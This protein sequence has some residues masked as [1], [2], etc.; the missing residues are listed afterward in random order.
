MK[1]DGS[2][3]NEGAD[4]KMK[5]DDQMNIKIPRE[6]KEDFY[7]T[8]KQSRINSSALIRRWIEQFVTKE[9]AES[10][11]DTISQETRLDL[12]KYM[13]TRLEPGDDHY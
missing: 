3:S 13:K 1:A 10:H 7:F 6:L 12:A 8:C 11:I 4:G 2:V 5:M 9:I